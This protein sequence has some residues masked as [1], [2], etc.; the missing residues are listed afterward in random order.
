MRMES[1]F[2]GC[3]PDGGQVECFILENEKGIRAEI[4]SYGGILKSLWVPDRSGNL[5]DI[6]MGYDTL[7]GYLADTRHFGSLIGR[8]GNRISGAS[9]RIGDTVYYLEKN[10]GE[11][12]L[13]SGKYCYDRR[14][15]VPR[16]EKDG[17]RASLLLSLQ[18]E[19]SPSFPG[20]A[21]VT[22]TYTL[23]EEDSLTIDYQ[24]V[25]DRDTIFNLT[26]HSYFN[27]AGHDS[28]TA[29]NQTLQLES[30]FFTPN[31]PECIPTGE[32][33]PVEGTAF[34][35]RRAKPIGRDIG[36]NEEQVRLFGGYDHNFVL[37]G[38]GYRK[39]GEAAD[40]GSGRVME[41]YTDQVGVQLYTGNFIKEEDEKG[42]GGA[43]YQ[44]HQA[45]CLETQHFPNSVNISHFPSPL[46]GA[47]QTYHAITAFRF[48][49]Q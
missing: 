4:L 28:G 43:A 18:D 9:Y 21:A 44:K 33:R 37:R 30:D 8:N 27:L 35:F 26:N 5:A 47:G 39:V 15:F 36:S 16:M 24:A 20:N 22:V 48:S 40:P 7:A 13:H 42:K 45:F 25:S 31:T 19:E 12:N 2:F 29:L 34:D 11:N 1:R 41:L 38:R 3:L 17:D 32:V 49:N 6:V 10:D 46:C 23:T 14:L